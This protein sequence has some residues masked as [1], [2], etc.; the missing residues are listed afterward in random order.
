[1]ALAEL[2][3]TE[4]LAQAPLSSHLQ[5]VSARFYKTREK[6]NTRPARSRS[7]GKDAT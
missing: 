2:K 7:C 4:G 6:A 5:R 3:K 1:M